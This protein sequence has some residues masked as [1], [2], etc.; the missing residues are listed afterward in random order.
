MAKLYLLLGGNLGNRER[1]FSD[2]RALLN[3]RVGKI[4]AHSG[5]YETE[6]WGF[7]SDDLFWNQALELETHLS[8]EEVLETV[9]AIEREIGRIRKE[10]QYESR[11][12][13]IDL[14]FFDDRIISSEALTIPHPRIVERKFVLVPLHE[15]AAAFIHPVF[16]KSIGE[17]LETCNDPL[18]VEKL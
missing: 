5:I 3:E 9:H 10:N 1:I 4:V 6:P 2:T 13:D 12:I 8:P 16:R 17:L 11:V 7:E 15:I 14:L 18:K